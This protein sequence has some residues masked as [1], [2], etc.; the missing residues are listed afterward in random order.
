MYT[1][2]PLPVRLKQFKDCI[3]T[4]ENDVLK[5]T[6]IFGKVMLKITLK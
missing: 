6:G 4:L 5:V 1:P 3:L 2:I